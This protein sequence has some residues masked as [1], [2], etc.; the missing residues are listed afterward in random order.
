MNN[1]KIIIY[2]GTSYISQE[3][4]KIL[5]KKFSKFVI[6]C[7]DQEVVKKYIKEIN[8]EK[9]KFD[10]HEVDILNLKKNYE[11]IENLDKDIEGLILSLIHI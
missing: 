8:N 6:F 2:G 11:L 1:N 9:I 4:L 5:S 3:L 10:I 7:R